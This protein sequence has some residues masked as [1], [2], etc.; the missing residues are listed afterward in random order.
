MRRGAGRLK[1]LLA[2]AACLCG[3]P[4]MAQAITEIAIYEGAPQFATGTG[5]TKVTRN[6]I[7]YWTTGTPPR[8]YQIIGEVTDKR[9]EKSDGGHAIGSPSIARKVKKAGGDAVI[10]QSQT[11]RGNPS[12]GGLFGLLVTGGVKT[13]TTMTVIKYLPADPSANRVQP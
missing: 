8:R 9:D 6:G 11:E 2:I 7:D 10:M 3:A 5:G 4:V 12:S 1:Q 13:M